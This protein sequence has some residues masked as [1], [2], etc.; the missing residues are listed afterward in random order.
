MYAVSLY[1]WEALSASML[2]VLQQEAMLDLLRGGLQWKHVLIEF[3]RI[4][5]E[6]YAEL[7]ENSV[8]Y[9]ALQSPEFEPLSSALLRMQ[10]F[11]KTLAHFF[12]LEDLPVVLKDQ[13][14]VDYVCYKGKIF[15]EKTIA[16]VFSEQ[17][18]FWANEMNDLLK[19][20][21]S[22]ALCREKLAD[23]ETM[24]KTPTSFT[25]S[26]FRACRTT[27]QE[28]QESARSQTFS[29]L[30]DMFTAS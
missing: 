9:I 22:Q 7:M 20:G 27:L 24:L 13:E 3:S 1:F 14:L 19:K 4:F 11:C 2:N 5:I 6:T 23:L 12:C 17:G 8:D 15:P 29:K 28:L 21:A 25:I 26:Q 16:T 10:Q 18:S 30:R